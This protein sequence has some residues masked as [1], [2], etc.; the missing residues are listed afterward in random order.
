MK[1]AFFVAGMIPTLALVLSIAFTPA[2]AVAEPARIAVISI[3]DVLERSTAA[4]AARRQIEVEVQK[5][6]QTLQKEQAAIEAMREE[7]EKR[8]SVWSDQVR[9]E[10]ERELQRRFRAF[11]GLNEDAQI[12][13][14]QKEQE[15][16]EPVLEALDKILAEFGA[17]NNYALILEYTLK[18]L[19]S[20]TGLLYADESLD[21]GEQVRQELDRRLR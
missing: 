21:I 11:E 15:V 18:G 5:Q 12:A 3:Q 1:K 2:V 10:R 9:A 7:I 17:E 19:R 20:R 14:Q 16:M 13:V 6:R 4:S 8:S